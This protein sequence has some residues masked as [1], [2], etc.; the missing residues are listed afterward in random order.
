VAGAADTAGKIKPQPPYVRSPMKRGYKIILGGVLTF[1]LLCGGCLYI[2][3]RPLVIVYSGATYREFMQAGGR[4]DGL[5]E[6]ATNIR[7]AR[8]SRGLGGRAHIVR[9]EAPVEDC[10]AFIAAEFATYAAAAGNPGAGPQYT[11]IVS[12]P[13]LPPAWGKTHGFRSLD[14]F[15]VQAIQRGLELKTDKAHNLRAWIDT[16]RGVLYLYWND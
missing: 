6:T 12:A 15:D 11:A 3:S 14:W 16:A 9:F 10:K 13:G 5:P 2:Y 8:S 1:C 7:L 4:V